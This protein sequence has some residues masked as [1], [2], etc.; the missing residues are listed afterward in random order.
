MSK[1]DNFSKM[2]DDFRKNE[3]RRML[4]AQE[5]LRQLQ[6]RKQTNVVSSSVKD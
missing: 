2:A 6:R 4:E 5:A 1:E 3:E